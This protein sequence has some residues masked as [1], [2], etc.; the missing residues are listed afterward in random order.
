MNDAPL[1]KLIDLKQPVYYA[2]SK[3][4]A[5]KSISLKKHI[6]TLLEEHARTTSHLQKPHS[7]L[8]RRL[9]GSAKP[10]DKDI[11]SIEDERLQYLLSK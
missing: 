7:L 6:E 9:I 5:N 1:R 8:V 3:E 10:V 4:A 11:S 2:L